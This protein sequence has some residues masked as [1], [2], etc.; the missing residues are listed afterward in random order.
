VAWLLDEGLDMEAKDTA[1]YTPL[2]CAV[3]YMQRGVIRLF[4]SRGADICT[5]DSQVTTSQEVSAHYHTA[6]WYRDYCYMTVVL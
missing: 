5:K 3:F 2:H 6:L 1:G 4:L